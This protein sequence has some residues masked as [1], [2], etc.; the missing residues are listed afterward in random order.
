M[1]GVDYA[2]IILGM[3]DFSRVD[4]ERLTLMR[5]TSED[6]EE[7]HQMYADPRVWEHFPSLRHANR[8]Q[9]EEVLRRQQRG[10]DEDG[11]ASWIARTPAPDGSGELIGVG[12]CTVRCGIAWNLGYR[13]TR[14][15][16]GRGYAQ[17]IIA[18]ARG[19]AAQVRP[20]LPITAY[21]LEHNVGS[22]RAAERALL[23]LVWRGVDVGNPDPSAV[24]LVYADR[25]L[26]K[27]LLDTLVQHE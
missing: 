1:S 7:M 13:L 24:R 22:K 8:S 20:E 27:A 11:L 26:D 19:A 9:T 10:W 18:A 2:G 21:L 17:E 14:H 5:P 25:A 12:G 3:I 16:W 6:L 15:A 4:T 23:H